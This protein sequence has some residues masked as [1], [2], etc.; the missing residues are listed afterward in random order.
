MDIYGFYGYPWTLW[1]SM[2][3]YGFYGYHGIHGYPWDPWIPMEW[4]GGCHMAGLSQGLVSAIWFGQKPAIEQTSH[5]VGYM[6]PYIL[7]YGWF[8]QWLVSVQI[9]WRKPALV[10]NQPYDNP[11]LIPWESMDPMDIHGSHDIHR[12]HRYPWISIGSM[13]IHRIHR[14]PWNPWI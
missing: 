7:P 13:D 1:I 3:I 4:V 8:A 12:I 11:R 9:K 6:V 10:T 14:Y 5:M 2:D